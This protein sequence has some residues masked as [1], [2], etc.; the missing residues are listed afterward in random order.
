MKNLII[1]RI[2]IVGQ[3]QDLSVISP[4][5]AA[6]ASYAFGMESAGLEYTFNG[7]CN[8]FLIWRYLNKHISLL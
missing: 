6:I 7:V 8:V 1:S 3:R 4:K 5:E 2:F